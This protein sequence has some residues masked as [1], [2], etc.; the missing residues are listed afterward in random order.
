MKYDIQCPTNLLMSLLIDEPTR[1][2]MSTSSLIDHIVSNTPEKISD[3][4]VIH[5]GISDHSLVFAI[6]KISVIKKQEHTVEIRNMKNFNEEKFIA[7]LSKQEWEY[8]YFF[9]DDPNAMWEIWKRIFLEV[10]DK[11][12]PLQHKKLRSKKV[13]WIT[14]NI[15]KLII[16][17]DKLKRKAILTNLENDWSNYKTSRNE[18]NIKLRNAKSN[19]YSTKIAGQKFDPKRAWKSINNLL[20]K[21]SKPTLVNELNLNENHLTSSK[22]IAEG[23]NN[24][25]SNIDPDLATKIDSSNFNFESYVKNTK[26][27]FAAFKPVVVSHV[28]RLLLGLSS[29]NE[30]LALTRFLPKLLK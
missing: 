26:S 11:H 18:V 24:Y 6:R 23:F 10:L 13:P 16:Q 2:T 20:G 17:R 8:V 21:Q 9:A 4:G 1:I 27:E 14:N 19:Y 12:A 5:T 22:G 30:L 7:E 29:N 25:F 3:S 15:K 28:H